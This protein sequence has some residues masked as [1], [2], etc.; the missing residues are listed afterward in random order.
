MLANQIVSVEK[1]GYALWVEE[2]YVVPE[3][4]R[5][6]IAAALLDY[7]A[8]EGRRSGVPAVELEVAPT[9]AAAFALYRGREFYGGH[10]Q[11]LTWHL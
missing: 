3:A 6:G 9:K 2:L 8:A 10:R 1:C 7:M 11:R 4:R 5:R